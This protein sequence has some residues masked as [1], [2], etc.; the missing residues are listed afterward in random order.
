MNEFEFF[1]EKNCQRRILVARENAVFLLAV[2]LDNGCSI[3][4]SELNDLAAAIEPNVKMVDFRINDGDIVVHWSGEYADVTSFPQYFTVNASMNSDR[5]F[6]FE[7]L[8][9]IHMFGRVYVLKDM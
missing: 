9:E 4:G 6:R 7:P 2:L 1:A 5:T 3:C 8:S